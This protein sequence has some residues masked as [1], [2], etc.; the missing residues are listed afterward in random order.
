MIDG[1][2]KIL[3]ANRRPSLDVNLMADLVRATG[4]VSY[5]YQ[6]GFERR[7]FDLLISEAWHVPATI[8]SSSNSI[9]ATE[10]HNILGLLIGFSGPNFL[11]FKR[12][13]SV[14][15]EEL[16]AR[17]EITQAEAIGLAERARKASYL[18]PSLP[19][20]AY[21]LH[22]LSVVPQHHRAGVGAA[23]VGHILVQA[24]Q[25]KFRTLQLDILSDNP[26]VSFYQALG[27]QILVETKSPELSRDHG[28]PSELRMAL[29]L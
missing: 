22:A 9:I 17:D 14:L 26:A 4:P 24:R 18:N 15:V 10:T 27:F 3:D 21:Y 29:T 23:L 1:K 8:F 28:F 16:V 5:G 12:N 7:L 20:S 6:F 11:I 2:M 25:N 19:K 13:F